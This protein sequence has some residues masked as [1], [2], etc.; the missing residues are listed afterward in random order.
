MTAQAKTYT[1]PPR[2]G[3]YQNILLAILF[4]TFGFVFYD[5]LALNYLAPYW[6][7]ELGLNHAALGL[8]GGI[9]ALTWAISGLLLGFISDKLDRRK[10]LL[11]IAVVGFSVF[12]ALSGLVG[13]LASLLLLRALMGITEGGVLP[14]SQTLMMFSSSE[15]RRGLNMGLLQG[16]SAGLLGGIIG[17]LVT[18]WMAEAWGWRSAFFFTIIPGLLLA[19]LVLFFV[20]ELRLRAQVSGTSGESVEAPTSAIPVDE[21]PA[22][23]GAA[24]RNRNIILCMLIAV[25]FITWFI[26]TQ[27][28]TATYI[29]ETKGWS[30]GQNSFALAG[31]GVGWVL[32]GACV[33]WMSDRFGRRGAII[34]FAAV[35]AFSPIVI[36]FAQTPALFF[37]GV[38]LTYTGMGC[39]TLYMATIP[40]ETVAPNI[41]ATCL[42]LIMGVGEIGGGFIAPWI[43]GVIAESISLNAT[44]WMCTG[45][46]VVVVILAAFLRETA[47]VRKTSNTSL[48][49]A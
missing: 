43:G 39:F 22:A 17:P 27:T 5:R 49:T 25:F 47:P 21:R 2:G 9:P 16:S 48:T 1:P 28:F 32:W 34:I 38:T 46:A 23:L 8:L 26:T 13:G 6:M 14:L 42:G 41:M 45:A 33:P 36:M 4:C 35:A 37:F 24:L 10:P 31:V 3:N 19:A 44:F 18:V 20:K 7:E 11:V 30:G 40:A 15:K 29:A 12:S